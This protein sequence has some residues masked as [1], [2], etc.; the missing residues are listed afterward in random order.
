MKKVLPIIT[1]FW[2]YCSLLVLFLISNLVEE[3]INAEFF[4]NIFLI[5]QAVFIIITVIG[6]IVY[7]KD[8][9]ALWWTRMIKL[10]HIP[11][12]IF[13]FI[14][15]V[16]FGLLCVIPVP[17]MIFLSST[18]IIVLFV[19]DVILMICSSLYGIIYMIRSKHKGYIPLIIM[20]FFFGLDVIAS[21]VACILQKNLLN[22]VQC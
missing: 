13:I 9:K 11:Y 19:S 10:V 18:M 14:V 15:G 12:Y 21:V 6:A 16:L 4:E 22:K 17:F 7:S 5:M 2:P 8:E 3:D 20:E 1:L